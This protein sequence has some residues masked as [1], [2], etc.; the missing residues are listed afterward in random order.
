MGLKGKI[1]VLI[2][3]LALYFI[4]T[5][6]YNNVILNKDYHK[7]YVLACEVKKGEVLNKDSLIEVS[8]KNKGVLSQVS[9]DLQTG[10]KLVF[11]KDHKQGDIVTNDSIIKEK[12]YILL[13]KD[14]EIVTIKIDEYEDNLCSS[15][16]PGDKVNI[17][18][19]A[20]TPEIVNIINDDNLESYISNLET[21]I[22]TVKLLEGI[23]VVKCYDSEGNN[24]S[25]GEKIQNIMF[26]VDKEM[27]MK[28]SNLKN[29]GKFSLS[30]CQ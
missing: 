22:S 19:S 7:M 13:S 10:E 4:I 27:A 17:F 25:S 21:G 5:L 14:K 11:L 18:V 16:S 30:L 24:V 6:F 26:E 15:I 28:V 1:I 2:L 12:D 23:E 8:Y 29:Y 20:R 3:S 9:L